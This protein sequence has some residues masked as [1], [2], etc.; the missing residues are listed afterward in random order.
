MARLH[1]GVAHGRRGVLAL[2]KVEVADIVANGPAEGVPDRPRRELASEVEGSHLEARLD[3]GEVARHVGAEGW[4]VPA[5]PLH[6]GAGEAAE[7][8]MGEARAPAVLSRRG[9]VAR[10]RPGIHIAGSGG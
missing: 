2:E 9:L 8:A 10:S 7:T 1:G 3:L 6:Q 4:P 5:G